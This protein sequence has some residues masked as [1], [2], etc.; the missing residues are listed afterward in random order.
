MSRN[1]TSNK[2]PSRHATLPSL[3]PQPTNRN[4]PALRLSFGEL[5]H[6][7]SQVPESLLADEKWADSSERMPK[8]VSHRG[9]RARNSGPVIAVSPVNVPAACWRWSRWAHSFP[10]TRWDVTLKRPSGPWERGTDVSTMGV[11]SGAGAFALI[12]RRE[13]LGVTTSR[14]S[15]S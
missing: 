11:G 8:P 12:L 1:H 13:W 4:L 9:L 5:L 15:L 7:R 10:G 2:T 3:D 14:T 6:R